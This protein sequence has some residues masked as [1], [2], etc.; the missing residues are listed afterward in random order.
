MPDQEELWNAHRKTLARVNLRLPK[1]ENLSAKRYAKRVCLHSEESR[2][3][4][5]RIGRRLDSNSQLMPTRAH[6]HH[7]KL[8]S[9][10]LAEKEG[11]PLLVPAQRVLV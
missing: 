2:R 3:G 9:R 8:T 11:T 10:D 4:Y 5:V 7:I 6:A 1:R